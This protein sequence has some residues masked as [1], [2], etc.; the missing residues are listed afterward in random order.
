MGAQ[1]VLTQ[2]LNLNWEGLSHAFLLPWL[3]KKKESQPKGPRT[4]NTAMAEHLEAAKKG[5]FDKMKLLEEEMAS[6]GEAKA[7]K[8][9]GKTAG[10]S[11]PLSKRQEKK[12]KAMAD[13]KKKT[14]D[15]LRGFLWLVL[16]L[17]ALALSLACPSYFRFPKIFPWSTSTDNITE[18]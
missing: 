17:A 3:P 16:I 1:A 12:L 5:D 8:A 15:P 13:S 14:G 7:A 9:D 2:G 11:E 6:M 18:G 4:I 10:T